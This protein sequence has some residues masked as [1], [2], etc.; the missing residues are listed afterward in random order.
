MS[1]DWLSNGFEYK[2]DL[3]AYFRRIGYEGSRAPTVET[4]YQLHWHH[5]RTIPYEWLDIH[6][7]KDKIDLAPDIVEKKLITN[8]RGGFC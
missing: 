8:G 1:K 2:P 4:L 7:T 3:E 5:V 6:I